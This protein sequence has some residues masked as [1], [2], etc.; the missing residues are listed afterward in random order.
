MTPNP[1]A[2]HY[3]ILLAEHYTWMFGVSFDQILAYA[4]GAPINVV[5]HGALTRSHA[6]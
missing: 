1:V 2:A 6:N 4:R 5:N 3:E